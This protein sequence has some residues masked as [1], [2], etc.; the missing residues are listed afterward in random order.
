[1]SYKLN[2][3]HIQNALKLSAPERYEYFIKRVADWRMLWALDAEDGWVIAT[4]D[5]GK[6]LFPVLA[7]SS[8]CGALCHGCLGW[9]KA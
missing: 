2:D 5:N 9:S 6:E 1:V 7:T 4:D 3:K 8:L